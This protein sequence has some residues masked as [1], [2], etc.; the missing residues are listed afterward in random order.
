MEQRT[1]NREEVAL[2]LMKHIQ[3]LEGN[4]GK[5][6]TKHEILALYA[7]CLLVTGGT[8]PGRAADA[9]RNG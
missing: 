1:Q 5:K 3:M 6:P 2:E 8:L 4:P 7:E 9:V